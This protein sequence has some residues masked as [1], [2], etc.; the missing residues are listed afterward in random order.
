MRRNMYLLTSFA[1]C[2][3]II[4]ASLGWTT[5]RACNC[6]AENT[7]HAIKTDG[8]TLN[9]DFPSDVMNGALHDSIFI[10]VSNVV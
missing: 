5:F 7:M 6:D 8:S 10:V 3:S 4:D 2:F 1:A 9:G